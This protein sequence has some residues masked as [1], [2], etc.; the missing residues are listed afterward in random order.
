MHGRLLIKARRKTTALHPAAAVACTAALVISCFLPLPA[1]TGP[2]PRP[3]AAATSRYEPIIA[4]TA[5]RFA[6][7]AAWI[8]AVIDVESHGD[9]RAVSPKGAI[10]LMQLMPKTYDALRARYALGADP[11]DPHDNVTAGA[12]YLRE[13]HDRFGAPGFLAAYNSGPDRYHDYL[14]T[15]RPLPLETRAYVA[16]LVL[17]LAG[18]LPEGA[19]IDTMQDA[20]WQ[21]ATLFASRLKASPKDSATVFVPA[22]SSRPK[23]IGTSRDDALVPPRGALF[24]SL[25]SKQDPR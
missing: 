15:A 7:P 16:Q 9:S 19:S 5:E 18:S 13:M 3:A 4:E 14:T 24:I 11:Y 2:V 8:R 17:L 6:I 10:G 20:N 22:S 21:S 1:R 25:S 23:D 12:A